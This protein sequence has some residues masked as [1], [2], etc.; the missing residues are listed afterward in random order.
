MEDIAVNYL[1]ANYG[2][3]G[4]VSIV[5]FMFIRSLLKHYKEQHE[6]ITR[7]LA[8]IKREYKDH[9]I[10]VNAQLITT[11]QDNTRAIL[12]YSKI[13]STQNKILIRKLRKEHKSGD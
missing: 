3:L 2:I 10:S 13:L 1:I 4:I 11:L 12:S 9:I 5:L 8:Q 6:L 7:E